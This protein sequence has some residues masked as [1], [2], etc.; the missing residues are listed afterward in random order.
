M[1]HALRSGG[2]GEGQFRATVPGRQHR[3]RVC[4]SN[5][6]DYPWPGLAPGHVRASLPILSLRATG[7]DASN[8]IV[9]IRCATVVE[10]SHWQARRRLARMARCRG[11]GISYVQFQVLGRAKSLSRI[12]AKFHRTTTGVVASGSSSREACMPCFAK[13]QVPATYRFQAGVCAEGC[14]FRIPPWFVYFP[15]YILLFGRPLAARHP[16]KGQTVDPPRSL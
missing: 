9:R 5:P 1:R 11:P 7:L 10:N 6:C 16:A 13:C 12:R 14:V 15:S 3:A 2:A 4:F 8:T